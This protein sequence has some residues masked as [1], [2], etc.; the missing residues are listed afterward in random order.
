MART[1]WNTDAKFHLDPP[2]ITDTQ[3]RQD[4]QTS[5]WQH[6]GRPINNSLLG[7]LYT[8]VCEHAM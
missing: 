4:R 6:S 7:I 8:F 3:N 1:L 2:N 5:V